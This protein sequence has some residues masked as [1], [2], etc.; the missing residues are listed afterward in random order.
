M[1]GVNSQVTVAVDAEWRGGEGE[2]RWRV[3]GGARVKRLPEQASLYKGNVPHGFNHGHR[4]LMDLGMP[5]TSG[6]FLMD[7]LFLKSPW[8]VRSASLVQSHDTATPGG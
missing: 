1:G 4:R 2:E 6:M 7:S 8:V 5:C 3:D